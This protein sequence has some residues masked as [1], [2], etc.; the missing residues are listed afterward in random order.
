MSN[1]E[2]TPHGVQ[3]RDVQMIQE[4]VEKLY[5]EKTTFRSWGESAVVLKWQDGALTL[6]T[7]RDEATYKP[8]SIKERER[9]E[10]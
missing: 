1:T 9:H 3:S 6:V 8:P 5:R 2:H 7:V 4:L 10:R